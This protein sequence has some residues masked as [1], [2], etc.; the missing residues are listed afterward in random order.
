MCIRCGAFLRLSSRYVD[1]IGV[2]C[3]VGG[4]LVHAGSGEVAVWSSF[5]LS[6]DGVRQP[7]QEPLVLLEELLILIESMEDSVFIYVALSEVF[8]NRGLHGAIIQ[9]EYMLMLCLEFVFK[10]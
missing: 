1:D 7:L 6:V 10:L 9:L 3:V 2:C 4:V 8:C 5:A